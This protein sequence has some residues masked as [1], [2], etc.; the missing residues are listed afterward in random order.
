MIGHLDHASRAPVRTEERTRLPLVNTFQ[1][2]GAPSAKGTG[3]GRCVS[4]LRRQSVETRGTPSIKP[5]AEEALADLA[6]AAALATEPVQEE[7]HP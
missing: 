7:C 5:Q 1:T 3:C 2:L 4:R 6:G